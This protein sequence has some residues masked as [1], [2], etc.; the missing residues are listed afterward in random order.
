MKT[1]SPAILAQLNSDKTEVFIL[2]EYDINA[3]GIPA[4][5]T[6]TA[7][8]DITMSN[9]ITYTANSKLVSAD[10]PRLTSVVDREAYKISFADVDNV[11]RAMFDA[12]VVGK[13]IKLTFGFIN[14]LSTTA[15]GSNGI[16]VLSGTP[17]KDMRDTICIYQGAVDTSAI[18]FNFSE[19]KVTATFESSSPM[20]SLD[21]R[22]TFMT[23]KQS[24]RDKYPNDA[25][26][27]VIHVGSGASLLKWGK[28]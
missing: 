22:N 17:F 12:G 1:I 8:Y 25:S 14:K 28:A 15:V 7:P 16:N 26:F 10:P 13:K 9:G 11:Y 24:M 27:D 20:G 23:S 18:D 21:M 6:T 3:L 5:A 19:G 4:E 2:I